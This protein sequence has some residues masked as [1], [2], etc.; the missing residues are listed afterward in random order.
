MAN[1]LTYLKVI[2]QYILAII[3]FPVK[4]I[5][6]LSGGGFI[7]DVGSNLTWLP[8]QALLIIISMLFVAVLFKVFGR[9][10]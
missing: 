5:Q 8:A 1:F 6:L 2:G 9:E 4:L 3:T 7:N 10:G